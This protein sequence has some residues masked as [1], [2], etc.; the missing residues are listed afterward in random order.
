MHADSVWWRALRDDLICGRIWQVNLRDVAEFES[1]LADVEFGGSWTLAEDV[2]DHH[3]L[4][5]KA[6]GKANTPAASN[7]CS[8]R[9]HLRDDVSFGDVGGIELAFHGDRQPIRHGGS[10]SFRRRELDEVRHRGFAAVDGDAHAGK[11]RH[12]PD[13]DKDHGHQDEAEEIA[14]RQNDSTALLDFGWEALNTCGRESDQ[15]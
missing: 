15:R 10:G 8:G 3:T 4:R 1:S 14:H 12:K 9:R 11:R 2:G 13:D 5:A 6:L 7:A